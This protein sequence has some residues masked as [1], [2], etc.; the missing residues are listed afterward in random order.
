LEKWGV[1]AHFVAHALDVGERAR[2][3]HKD[4]LLLIV[5]LL[6][7]AQDSHA[8][9]PF[10]TVPLGIILSEH[11]LVTVSSQETAL[12]RDFSAGR[13]PDLSTA[14]H[15]RFILQLLLRIT[16]Q[17]LKSLHEIDTEVDEL[18]SRLQRSLQNREV[19]GLLK[20]QKSLVYFTTALQSNQLM[21]ER[22]QKSEPLSSPEDQNLLEDV[23]IEVRQAIELSAISEN[24][25]SQ[26]MD[27]FA[28]I[29]SNNLN[30]VMKFLASVTI[31][32]SLPILIASFYGMNV[33]L[34]GED[35]P[36][37]FLFILIGSALLTLIISYIF[38][39]KD[40]L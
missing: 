1:P 31:I 2:T 36:L 16:D 40:W 21:L 22:L 19:L 13:V 27:A 38:R 4:N 34:P 7:H 14:Q 6:P 9:V 37:A 17:Y 25:L 24:M 26:T 39:K 28:S 5:L 10:T 23:L 33:A 3:E 12:I 20:Y 30:V 35:D 11:T 29:I 18:E 15:S 32:I 8:A